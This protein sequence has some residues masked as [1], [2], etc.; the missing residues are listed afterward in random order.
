MRC[1]PPEIREEPFF[2][3]GLCAK[4]EDLLFPQQIYGKS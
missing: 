1:P 4:F 2:T 3:L